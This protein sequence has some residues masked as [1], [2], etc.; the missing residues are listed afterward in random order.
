MIAYSG[1]IRDPLSEKSV[2]FL[3]RFIRWP[4]TNRDPIGE[5]P[6]FTGEEIA[7][8]QTFGP[9]GLGEFLNQVRSLKRS[10]SNDD[11]QPFQ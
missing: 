10:I 11:V 8:M 2:A 6:A 9:R 1:N 5:E 4:E 7:K 3:Y